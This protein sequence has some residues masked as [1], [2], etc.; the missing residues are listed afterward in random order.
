MEERKIAI[1]NFIIFAA[2]RV[3]LGAGIGLLLSGRLN[4]DQRKSAGIALV[5]VGAA[6]TV[7]LAINIIGRRSKLFSDLSQAA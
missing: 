4:R 6:T 3:A 2:T 1:A 7:P 5:A